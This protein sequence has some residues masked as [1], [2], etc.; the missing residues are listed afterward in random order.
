MY[1]KNIFNLKN[2]KIVVVGGNGKVG[3]KIIDILSS[4]CKSLFVLSRKIPN[5]KIK[6]VK[7]FSVDQTEEKSVKQILK[8]ISKP[9]PPDVFI[10]SS[11]V[12]PMTNYLSDSKDKWAESMRV[13]ATGMFIICREFA[14][15]MKKNKK[16]SI[17]MISSIYS[18]VGPDEE[19]Y[20]GVD[21]ETEPDYPFIK[22]GLN[23]FSKYLAAK[24]A[25][26]NIRVNSLVL[27]GVKNFQK[28]IFLKNYNR[29]L[30]LKRMANI[31]D[32]SG[33]IIFLSSDASKYMTGT[34]LIVDGGYTAI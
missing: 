14:N 12:R 13:N 2:K 7:Y 21:F 19:N 11:L 33:P 34:N 20:K 1:K 6:N 31:D 15:A 4:Q 26:Y 23:S 28:K 3:R 17:I 27:G 22:G 25:K 24:Y 8:K 30:L 29:K 32:I 18:L 10:Y 9:N 5:T 16:G